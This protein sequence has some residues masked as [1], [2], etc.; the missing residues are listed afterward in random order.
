MTRSRAPRAAAL[1]LAL[2]TLGQLALAASH[3]HSAPGSPGLRA[4][5]DARAAGQARGA[6]EPGA[7]P[8]C[9]G[10]LHPRDLLPRSAAPAS[11]PSPPGVAQPDPA[12]EHPRS[13]ALSASTDPRAPPSSS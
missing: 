10:L 4:A 6:D 8:V 3:A 12:R 7:C 2:A 5:A 11:A 9:K 1:V 13:A